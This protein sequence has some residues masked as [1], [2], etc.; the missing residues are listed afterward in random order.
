EPWDGERVAV[1]RRLSH[2]RVVTPA[3]EGDGQAVRLDDHRS[4][5][6]HEPPVQLLRVGLLEALQTARQPAVTAIGKYRQRGV[7]V[8]VQPH[9][10]GQ[11]VEVEEVH[12]HPEAAFDPIA[13]GVADDQ[14]TRCLLEVV[15]E[16]Q[17]RPLTAQAGHGD[18]AEWTIVA[19]QSYRALEV[20]DV[21]MTPL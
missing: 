10:A 3:V 2:D 16:N 14:I 6:L 7:E 9:L 5:R 12:A 17:S 13:T 20:T 8:H 15:R 1:Q 18:L 19:P 21:H 11:A 4:G